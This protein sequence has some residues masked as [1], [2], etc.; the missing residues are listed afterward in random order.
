[1][2]SHFPEM[3]TQMANK[4][5]NIVNFIMCQDSVNKKHHGIFSYLPD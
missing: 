4:C 3:E 2:N 5:E 1:M